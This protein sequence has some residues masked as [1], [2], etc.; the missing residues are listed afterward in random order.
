VKAERKVVRSE[1]QR[2]K[3][4]ETGVILERDP[5]EHGYSSRAALWW[6]FIAPDPDLAPLGAAVEP[7]GI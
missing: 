2:L 1:F 5:V 6:K 7:G 3:A 4:I